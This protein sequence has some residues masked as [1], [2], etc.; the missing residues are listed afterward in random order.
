[1]KSIFS[2]LLLCLVLFVAPASSMDTGPDVTSSEITYAIGTEVASSAVF[3]VDTPCLVNVPITGSEV[4]VYAALK[5][6]DDAIQ[7]KLDLPYD[8]FISRLSRH[9]V[10]STSHNSGNLRHL[11]RLKYSR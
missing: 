6:D 1:M 2:L 9:S 8:Q 5:T 4:F 11:H 10:A 3:V 7:P